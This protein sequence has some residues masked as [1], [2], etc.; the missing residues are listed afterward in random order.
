MPLC[1][2]HDIAESFYLNLKHSDWLHMLLLPVAVFWFC[3]TAFVF[4]LQ[5][6]KGVCK[7]SLESEEA[8]CSC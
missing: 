4:Y 8:E 5:P 6:V 7:L 1:I 3:A 2:S